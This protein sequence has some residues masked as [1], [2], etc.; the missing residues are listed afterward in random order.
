[1]DDLDLRRLGDIPDPFADA[2]GKPLASPAS[3]GERPTSRALAALAPSSSRA[4]VRAIRMGAIA[5]ALL[6]QAVLLLLERRADLATTSS[7]SLAI[8]L[9]VPLVATLLAL[10]AATRPG[11]LGLGEST[12]RLMALVGAAV[13]VFAVGTLFAAPSDTE[14]FWSHT[15]RCMG[16][17]AALAAVPL[18]VGVGSFR[19][20]FVTA[21]RWRCAA[22]G[23]AAGA[24]A[25]ATM[26]IACSTDG[27]LH[28]LVGHGAMML[29]GGGVGAALGRAIR[30]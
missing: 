28:V 27:V 5:I 16:V 4:R 18:A 7:S 12:G 25:A 20:A 2:A 29:V 14:A 6:A 10:A 21:A 13:A 30:A 15:L 22:L 8:G 3:H 9:G 19:H 23:V 17:T 1:M 24:L 26:S 11:A